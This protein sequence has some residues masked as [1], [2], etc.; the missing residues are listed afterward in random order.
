[1]R[2]SRLSGVVAAVPTPVTE[3][4]RPCAERFLRH[5]AWALDHGCDGVNVLGTT[6][7]ANSLPPDERMSL[8]KVAAQELDGSR[9][10]VGT[11]APDVETTVQMTRAACEAGFAAALV[12][13]PFYYKAVTDDGLFEWFE[14]VVLATEA[15]PIPLYL[16]NFPQMTGIRFSPELARR[17][18]RTYPDRVLGAKDSSGDLAYAAELAAID[19]FDVFPSSEAALA[20]SRTDR[21][22][23]CI[24]ATVNVTARASAALWRSPDDGGLLKA[25]S[26]IRAA[27]SSVPLIPA[28][29]HMVGRIHGDREFARVLP[30]HSTLTEEAAGFLDGLPL[31]A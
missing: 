18:A 13:P 1:M 8:M 17:L 14:R 7:E 11:G 21:F 6:G 26:E 27:I 30:P 12:L 20:R 15:T 31:P 24:S 25:V 16:Y 2:E 4:G 22:A 9:M 29:K 19:G 5:C 28:V 10:M 23:G 3:A